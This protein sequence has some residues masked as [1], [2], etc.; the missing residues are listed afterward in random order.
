MEQSHSQ[1]LIIKEVVYLSG[2]FHIGIECSTLGGTENL[3]ESNTM[4]EKT[5][6]QISM[7]ENHQRM[8]GNL[9]LTR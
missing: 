3:A 2:L 9:G 4:V 8:L 6:G 1:I 7:N 5:Q